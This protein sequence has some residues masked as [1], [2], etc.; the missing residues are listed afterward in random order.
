MSVRNQR[1]ISMIRLLYESLL[2]SHEGQTPAL[3]S[4]LER[5]T[6]EEAVCSASSANVY[7]TEKIGAVAHQ[8]ILD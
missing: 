7:D 4:C 1:S 6:L 5:E 2:R 8:V 3:W